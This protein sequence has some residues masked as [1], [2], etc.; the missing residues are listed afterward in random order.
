MN[1]VN[2]TY[3]AGPAPYHPL[4][5]RRG[6]DELHPQGQCEDCELFRNLKIAKMQVERKLFEKNLCHEIVNSITHMVAWT[7]KR[8]LD[9]N[10]EGELMGLI[11]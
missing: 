4:V 11:Q 5:C 9:S 8:G 2:Y 7:S 6:F 10:Y 3:P 1:Y